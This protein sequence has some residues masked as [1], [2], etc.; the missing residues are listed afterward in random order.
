MVHHQLSLP[1][2]FSH[3]I[4]YGARDHHIHIHH[5][6]L[7]QFLLLVGQAPERRASSTLSP[8][9]VTVGALSISEYLGHPGTISAKLLL[10]IS[11]FDNVG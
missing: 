9:T 6:Q 11:R 2:D 4:R 5:R 10:S 3:I 7:R 1:S 8:E